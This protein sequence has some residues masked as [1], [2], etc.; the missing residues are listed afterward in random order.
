MRKHTKQIYVSY[1]WKLSIIW[2]KKCII[3]KDTTPYIG[4]VYL[5]NNSDIYNFFYI[6]YRLET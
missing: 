3:D 5:L 4:C 6:K 1:V 2:F